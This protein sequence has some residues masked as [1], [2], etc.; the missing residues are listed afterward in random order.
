VLSRKKIIGQSI[1]C[2]KSFLL[3]RPVSSSATRIKA[4][5]HAGLIW[6]HEMVKAPTTNSTKP[7][8]RA[9]LGH[10]DRAQQGVLLALPGLGQ[11]RLRLAA[12]SS[13]ASPRRA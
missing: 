7:Q 8:Q 1:F 6:C 2:W 10:R 12:R 9:L 5:S 11:R 13:A 3:T 4:A